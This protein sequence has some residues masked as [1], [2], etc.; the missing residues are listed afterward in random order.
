MVINNKEGK[1]DFEL[2]RQEAESKNKSLEIEQKNY[3]YVLKEGILNEER[4]KDDY[5]KLLINQKQL[6]SI[7]SQRNTWIEALKA[8][9]LIKEI[10]PEVEIIFQPKVKEADKT[11]IKAI[12]QDFNF[13]IQEEQSKTLELKVKLKAD[14]VALKDKLK[15]LEQR[16]I[17]WEISI[18]IKEETTLETF[19]N[20]YKNKL[21]STRT[22]IESSNAKIVS[23]TMS[24]NLL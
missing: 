12:I 18:G 20:E 13:K 8:K 17:E 11:E 9:K 19:V 4:K 21:S 5:D 2:A 6:E 1:S 22:E 7:R 23:L 3:E 15:E 14:D 24:S 10:T 16:K